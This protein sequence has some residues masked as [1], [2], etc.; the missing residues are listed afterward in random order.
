MNISEIH[1]DRYGPLRHP[2][3]ECTGGLEVFYGP[4][5]S[6][7]TLLLESIL[8]LLDPAI[9]SHYDHIDRVTDPPAGH[10]VVAANG[11]S[12]TLNGGLAV[13]DISNIRPPHLQNIYAVRDA[14]LRLDAEHSFYRSLTEQIGDLHTTEIEAI[15]DELEARGRL[16]PENR[17]I[18]SSE[19]NDDAKAVKQDAETLARRIEAYVEDAAETG[20]DQMERRLISL[21]STRNQKQAAYD[22]QERAKVAR[23]HERLSNRLATFQDSQSELESITNVSKDGL[24][25]LSTLQP[26][27]LT[28]RNET[29]QLTRKIEAKDAE[30]RELTQ[31]LHEATSEL[32]PLESQESHVD[33]VEESLDGVDSGGVDAS[34]NRSLSLARPVAV[35]GVV[36]GGLAAIVAAALS[37]PTLLGVG[38]ALSLLGVFAIGWYV[39]ASRQLAA[40]E[41][42]RTAIVTEA[43]AAG[44][45]VTTV[46][47]VRPAIQSFRNR[48]A[49]ARESVET[50]EGERARVEEVLETHRERV[51]ELEEEIS[52]L[53]AEL[54]ALLDEARVE[55]LEAYRSVYQHRDDLQRSLEQAK[56]VLESE[57]GEPDD[58]A[59]MSRSAYWKSE[60]RSLEDKHALDGVDSEQ[61]DETQYQQLRQELDEIEAEI[62]AL[63]GELDDHR[64]RLDEFDQ[65]ARELD[66]KPFV[67]SAVQLEA[68]TLEGA[69]RLRER[70][71][72]VVESID[73]DA[74]IS[75]A[76][77][78]IFDDLEGDE[79]EKITDLFQPD[80]RASAVF[81]T[82][83]DGRYEQVAYDADARTLRIQHNGGQSRSVEEVSHGT[84]EQLY[85]AARLS[86]GERLLGSE[87]GFF[88]MDD[89]LLPSDETRLRAGF[90]V[91]ETFVEEGWQILY[92]TAKREI[93]EQLAVDRGLEITTLESL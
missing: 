48:L 92:F 63:K 88:L 23:R 17:N 67:D 61:F 39:R 87:P 93:G 60:L 53:Q 57:L 64:Q 27:I 30:R 43:Q 38:A 22:F 15:K 44:L 85:L 28:K 54:Q 8:R 84:R 77:L 49:A 72:A 34:T 70:L 20:I 76:A 86:L 1:I 16:T 42:Q 7:K 65:R 58:G 29:E 11:D 74:A 3:H 66:T 14:D 90:D 47:E 56:E 13:S 24:E 89:A 73:Q 4:N 55:T 45:E 18:S 83:T 69:T 52:E 6:G 51:D 36:T 25:T 35:G 46:D 78:D 81:D 19:A 21:R 37:Q 82:I 80:G 71:E 91:L 79:E 2:N 62:D 40:A 75:R 32:K 9:V 50:I 5:E 12:R 59:S 68:R 26:T 10:L 41:Q 31:R 33:S